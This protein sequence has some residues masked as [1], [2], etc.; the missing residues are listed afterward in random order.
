MSNIISY[1]PNV[2]GRE[3][4]MLENTTATMSDSQK[5]Q[6]AAI[7]AEQR[8][9]PMV[10]LGLGLLG[11]MGIGGVNRFYVRKIGTGLLYLFTGGLFLIGTILDIFKYRDLAYGYNEEKALDIAMMVK[12]ADS[13]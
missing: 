6:F 9:E 1:L 12:K 3:L 11:F 4:F 13:F 5:R 7:Y 8:R 2:E 10:V